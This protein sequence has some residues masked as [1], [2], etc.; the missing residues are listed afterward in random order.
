MTILANGGTLTAHYVYSGFADYFGGH[1][2]ANDEDRKEFLLYAYYGRKTSLADIVDELVFRVGGG[3]SC[4]DIPDDITDSDVRDAIMTTALSAIGRADVADGIIAECSAEY[5][6]CAECHKCGA[7]LRDVADGD[8]CPACH[9]WNDHGDSPI[10]VVVLEYVCPEGADDREEC[11][12]ATVLRANVCR[13]TAIVTL[14]SRPGGDLR[15]TG[16]RENSDF[17]FDFRAGACILVLFG[18][19]AAGRIG[20]QWAAGRPGGQQSQLHHRGSS[21]YERNADDAEWFVCAD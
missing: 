4:E 2:C 11:E 5:G 1:G 10:F 7:S 8:P 19:R 6:E 20:R 3:P 17:L 13:M 21:N 14:N 9:D 15:P 16:G 18:R 12:G